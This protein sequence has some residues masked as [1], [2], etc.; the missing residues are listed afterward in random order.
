M[1]HIA[2]SEQVF[3]YVGI[4]AW[5]GIVRYLQ[6]TKRRGGASWGSLLLCQIMT[7]CFVGFIIYLLCVLEGMGELSTLAAC[8]VSG[9]LGDRFLSTLWSKV[10]AIR[11][12]K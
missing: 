9:S 12:S 4:S 1:E 2:L 11:K 8:G 6:V 3:Y 10:E 7:S 5:G